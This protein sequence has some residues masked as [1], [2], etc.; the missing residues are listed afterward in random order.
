MMLSQT[1]PCLARNALF[2][3]KNNMQMLF[4]KMFHDAHAVRFEDDRTGCFHFLFMLIKTEVKDNWNIEQIL[5]HA[6]KSN[7]R[8]R[9][10]CAGLWLD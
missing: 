8:S 7:N 3:P 1:Y 2:V 5:D 6:M 9:K 10:I 4:I